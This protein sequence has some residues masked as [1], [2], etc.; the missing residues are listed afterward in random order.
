MKTLVAL[1]ALP[2]EYA[3]FQEQF[4]VIGDHSTDRHIRLEHETGVANVRL[5]SILAEQMGAQSALH[6]ADDV[7]ID[8]LPDMIVVIGIAGGISGDVQIGDVCIS[9]QVLDVLQNTKNS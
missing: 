4:A 5:I 9:N 1:I 6:S 7:I 3:I 8:F 2:E